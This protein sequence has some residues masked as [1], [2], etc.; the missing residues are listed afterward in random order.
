M[1]KNWLNMSDSSILDEN[2]FV[3]IRLNLFYANKI[4]MKLTFLYYYS[5]IV[6]NSS[7]S[8]CLSKYVLNFDSLVMIII[9][10]SV[11]TGVYAHYKCIHCF[12]TVWSN[13]STG[14]FDQC[15]IC[16]TWYP[17]CGTC[18]KYGRIKHQDDI[19]KEVRWHENS[20]YVDDE[21]KKSKK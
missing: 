12:Y 20:E 10:E 14:S 5:F 3:C 17:S 15:N 7:Y 9:N 6:F 4:E 11:E 8:H 21:K 13:N 1:K 2:I 19:E 18:K 16:K